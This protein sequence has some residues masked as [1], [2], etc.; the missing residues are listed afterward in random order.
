MAANFLL[1]ILA[2]PFLSTALG[3]NSFGKLAI[4]QSITIVLC[5]IVDFGFILVAAR[6][7]ATA[8]GTN[9]I[10]DIYS[11][12]QNTRLLL[13]VVALLVAAVLIY[14]RIL[15]ID[16]TLLLATTAPAISGTALQATWL[17]Q[18]KGYFGWLA[19]SNVISKLC[20]L[21]FIILAV[22]SENDLTLAGLAFG[23]TYL[24]GG[25][26]LFLAARK[27][28]VKWKFRISFVESRE[29]ISSSIR[30]FF[31]LALL[32]F[33]TQ[34]LITMTGAFVSPA[35][36]G[37]LSATDKIIRSVAALGVPF[38]NALFPV[39]SKLY[40]EPHGEAQKLRRRVLAGLLSLSFIGSASIFLSADYV[41]FLMM[42][43]DSAELGF[44]LRLSSPIPIFVAIGVVYG[45]LTLIPAG[46]DQDYLR[47]ILFSEI[48]AFVAFVAALNLTPQLSG[49]T[50]I[51]VAESCLAAL[52]FLAARTQIKKNTPHKKY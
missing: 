9:E 47:S 4:A 5:Q 22:N 39:F 27:V 43:R 24:L 28:G 32:S 6:Q 49:L 11:K 1:P 23:S 3:T 48:A 46:N 44:F 18:G 50:G 19:A 34:I 38:A 40:I 26:I 31:S 51:V 8:R 7:V 2:L 36:A 13:A 35:A 29:A 37:I 12:T 30:S 10:N 42:P 14:A 52:M 15:P 33:H 45:G 41:A 17:F 21:I 20:F 25:A 16:S